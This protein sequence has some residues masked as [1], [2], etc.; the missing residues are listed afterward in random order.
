MPLVEKKLGLCTC[1]ELE[2]WEY[3]NCPFALL[4]NELFSA[5]GCSCYDLPGDLTLFEVL[6]KYSFDLSCK[7][8]R[9]LYDALNA[10]LSDTIIEFEEE[11]NATGTKE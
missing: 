9:L 7:S 10:I 1:S 8:H 3:E 6:E 2:C 11:E 4:D 5:R